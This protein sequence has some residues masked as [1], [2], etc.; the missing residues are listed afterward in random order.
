MRILIFGGSFDPPHLGHA[1]LLKAAVR[2]LTPDRVLIVPAYQAPLKGRPGASAAERLKMLRLV[3]PKA[4]LELSELRSRRKVYTVDTLARLRRRFPTAELHFVVG[5][6]SAANF[7]RWKNPGR[8]KALAHWWT[9]TRPAPTKS[10]RHR[11]RY[12]NG[13]GTGQPPRFFGKIAGRMPDV[14]STEIRRRLALGLGIDGLVAAAVAREIGR[15]KLYGAALL[16]TLKRS[17]KPERF[18][19]T[20]CVAELADALARRHRLNAEK[21]RLAGLLH[22]LGRSIPV[23][24][25][26]AY[27]KKHRLRIEDAAGIAA[28]QPILFHA[29]ISADLARRRLG[30]DD[31]EVLSAVEKHTLGGREM[32]ALDRLLYVADACSKDRG[33]AAAPRLRALAERD[34][35]AAFAAVVREKLSYVREGGFWIHP[36]AKVLWNSL[37][38]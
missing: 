8:L 9:A 32:S 16:G 20:L 6:D 15:R 22:D 13:A 28:N 4:R 12:R 35:D 19:H 14:S 11:P 5:S 23:P 25:M 21:A 3:F 17:L 2:Q 1:A 24:E 34:L 37:K 31:P 33:H 10:V 26:A 18:H 7:S 27:A 30:V 36:L 38:K 29:H